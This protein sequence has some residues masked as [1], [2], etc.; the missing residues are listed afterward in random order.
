MEKPLS[1][2]CERNQVLI[3]DILMF[4]LKDKKSVLEIGSG[5]GQHAV[6]FS[7]HMPHLVWQ[8]S[9]LPDKHA[10]IIAWIEDSQLSN[11]LRPLSLDVN[12]DTFP[13]QEFDSVFTANTCHIMGWQSVLHLIEKVSKT[14]IPGGLF[15][16]YGPFNFDGEYTAESNRAFDRMLKMENP[17]MGIRNFEDLSEHS[18]RH[19]LQ[20]INKYSMPANNFILTFQKK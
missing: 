10:G 9:D 8:T 17:I 11:V 16:I 5:T 6:F 7:K 19:R 13:H 20:F 1:P 4:L 18:S 14:L 3:L 12:Y 15:I 2:S